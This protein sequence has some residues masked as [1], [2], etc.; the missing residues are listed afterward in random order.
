MVSN[1]S[2]ISLYLCLVAASTCGVP[3]LAS[4]ASG[5]SFFAS[6]LSLRTSGCILLMYLC[7][8]VAKNCAGS[9]FNLRISW[10]V[11]SA[12]NSLSFA[13][14][15]LVFPS[16]PF[17]GFAITSLA[18]LGCSSSSFEHFFILLLHPMHLPILLLGFCY[19]FKS[20]LLLL[21]LICD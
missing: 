5:N 13:E 9:C 20:F 17:L 14:Y 11:S 2:M 8:T 12:S 7:G 1:S 3:L 4:S 16:G 19:I 15:S 18:T 10:V 6:S 21:L